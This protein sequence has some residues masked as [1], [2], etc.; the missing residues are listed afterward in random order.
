[1]NMDNKN[2]FEDFISNPIMEEY[3]KYCDFRLH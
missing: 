2:N 1:M 3:I